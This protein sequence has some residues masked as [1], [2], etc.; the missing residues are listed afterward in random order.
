MT[1][2]QKFAENSEAGPC[3]DEKA[4]LSLNPKILGRM[5][6][7]SEYYDEALAREYRQA[8]LRAEGEVFEKTMGAPVSFIEST[9][10]SVTVTSTHLTF[11]QQNKLE[12]LEQKVD[13]SGREIGQL[14]QTYDQ[15]DKL[16]DRVNQSG[17]VMGGQQ[18]E[19]ERLKQEI[20]LVKKE[21]AQFKLDLSEIRDI[22]RT[23]TGAS[24]HSF[25]PAS[26][27]EE[28]PSSAEV[29]PLADEE[30][31]SEPEVESTEFEEQSSELEA[32]ST[33]LEE[34]SSELEIEST[35]YE[36]SSPKPEIESTRLAERTPESEYQPSEPRPASESIVPPAPEVT[37]DTLL[38]HYQINRTELAGHLQKRFEGA[39]ATKL[40]EL[41]MRMLLIF[42]SGNVPATLDGLIDK[43]YDMHKLFSS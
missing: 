16:L 40:K 10:E 14:K 38:D 22:V 11:E 30:R 3:T 25:D 34:Y 27:P 31:F 26:A 43:A 24:E 28:Q 39:D 21:N 20:E 1:D 2:T 36:E 13:D 37:I 9:P 7:I 5:K 41:A 19:I 23:L 18:E 29:Q 6:R 35:Q 8:E 12:S 4:T 33:E 42:R 17:A 32:E 15:Y